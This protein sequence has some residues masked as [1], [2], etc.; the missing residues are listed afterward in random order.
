LAFK[1]IAHALPPGSLASFSLHAESTKAIESG[2]PEVDECW[3]CRTSLEQE[4]W[5]DSLRRPPALAESVVAHMPLP[6]KSYPLRRKV[7]LGLAGLGFSRQ[8]QHDQ[9]A[10]CVLPCVPD[11]DRIHLA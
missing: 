1:A 8:R 9:P 2:A 3:K 10:A 6:V 5:P 4:F 7:G 11:C